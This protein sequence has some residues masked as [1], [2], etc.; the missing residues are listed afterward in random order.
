MTY[1]DGTQ[2]E[3]EVVIFGDVNCDG[4]YNGTDSIIV[5]C[6]ANGMLTKDDVGDAAYEAADCNHDGLIDALDVALLEQAGML[7]TNIDQSKPA[8]ELIETSSVYVEYLDLMDQ[9]PEIEFKEPVDNS[10]SE[11]IKTELSM[12]EIIIKLIKS[13]FETLLTYL[14]VK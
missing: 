8:E 10:R 9:S 13:I 12:V 6:L 3:Y 4:W 7:L 2:E 11:P 14:L 5:S 1:G